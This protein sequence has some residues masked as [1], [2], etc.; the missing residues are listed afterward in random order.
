MPTIA[1]QQAFGPGVDEISDAGFTS[2]G[3]IM[4]ARDASSRRSSRSSFASRTHVLFMAVSLTLS[5][6]L[7]LIQR[8]HVQNV[9]LSTD[10]SLYDLH[11]LVRNSSSSPS[12]PLDN[13]FEIKPAPKRHF[14][15]AI[16]WLRLP[17]TASTS[18]AQ[19][20]ISPLHRAGAF[21]N[22]E[23][24]PN[25]CI[26]GVGGC[27][28]FWKGMTWNNDFVRKKGFTQH[29]NTSARRSFVVPGYIGSNNSS[30]RC[31]P[32]TGTGA[33]KTLC[34]EYDYRTSTMNFGPHRRPTKPQQ[35]G[36]PVKPKPTKVQANFDFGPMTATHVGLDPS[37]FGW[38]MPSNPMVFST[39]R[40]PVERL[41]SSFHYGIQFGG[42]RPGQ[43]ERCDLPGAGKGKGRVNRWNA[44]V[45]KARETAT[46]QHNWTEYQ[47]LLRT[48]LDIC[49]FAADNAYVQFLDPYT[50]D[51]D[52]AISNLEKYVIVGLQ[53][54]M[55]ETVKRWIN[56][57]KNSCRAHPN[58]DTMYGK[59]F[60]KIL[61]DMQRN[62][63]FDRKRQSTV[64]LKSKTRGQTPN[65]S[66]V[67]RLLLEL[68]VEDDT[69][70]QDTTPSSEI[71]LV[72]PDINNF[73][74]DLQSLIRKL[75]AGDE[76]IYKR[77]LQLYE[78]Q[79]NWGQS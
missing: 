79:R 34:Q 37:L 55:D 5:A 39:F 45:V 36:K 64:D 23:V 67:A 70:E 51:M 59:V 41:L 6:S 35:P 40:S 21:T 75:T 60:Q 73:D 25:T 76:V 8:V 13:R 30:Q 56:I 29:H 68:S 38:V 72:S 57:T 10:H 2:Q 16:S 9:S 77:V 53:T 26:E 47:S 43:V 33:P 46:L 24:G 58:Y 11:T 78:E 7:F 27:A 52:L 19:S 44:I 20:F 48:Y 71:K 62:G 18:I 4:V 1:A 54:D 69:P 22:T 15:C 61:L 28:R 49:S 42:G 50:K 31:F 74:Q 63:G 65:K 3:I 12:R 66:T 17:K 14:D 32:M